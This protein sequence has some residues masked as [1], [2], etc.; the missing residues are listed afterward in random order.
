MLFYFLLIC[1][2]SIGVKCEQTSEEFFFGEDESDLH[3]NEGTWSEILE[4][5]KII[6]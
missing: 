2:Y 3:D 1:S 5:R 6:K 4:K